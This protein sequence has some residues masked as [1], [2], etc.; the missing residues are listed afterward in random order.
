MMTVINC[1]ACNKKLKKGE[2]ELCEKTNTTECAECSYREMNGTKTIEK[3]NTW[4]KKP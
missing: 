3:F 4:L 1:S 2:K